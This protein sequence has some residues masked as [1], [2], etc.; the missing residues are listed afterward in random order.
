MHN[1]PTPKPV[2]SHPVS[3]RRVREKG[4]AIIISSIMMMFTV[5]SVGLAIDG[6]VAYFVKGRLMAAVDSAALAAGRSLN[7]ADDLDMV[8][9]VATTGAT[10]F[11]QANFPDRFMGTDPTKTKIDPDFEM[12]M[13]NGSPTG[14][15]KVRVDGEVVAP[16]YFMKIF[17]VP[18]M[19][20]VAS[21]TATRRTLVMMLILD[22]SGSMGTRQTSVG[23]IPATVTSTSRA[24]DAMIYSAAKFIRYF[25]PYDRVGF[26]TFSSSSRVVY[27]PSTNFKDGGSA[28]MT[29]DLAALNCS[30]GTNTAPA[31]NI[32]WDQVRGVGLKL[33]LNSIVLF[34]DVAQIRGHALRPRPDIFSHK[35]PANQF[36]LALSRSERSIYV[37]PHQDGDGSNLSGAT[38]A[39]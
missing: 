34:T 33:A 2:T 29:D 6:G 3:S 23:T 24:C 26:A 15:L 27:A 36:G 38:D 17:N 21:G 22:V 10:R 13:S 18:S 25:S 16:T 19:K 30:G 20:I 35:R 39:L 4:I 9:Q 5:G 8:E 32:S 28:G 12:I 1:E 14:V 31:M 37:L 11:F 7:L